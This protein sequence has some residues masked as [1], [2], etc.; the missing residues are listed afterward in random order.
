MF[1]R[2]M[3]SLKYVLPRLFVFENRKILIQF[4]PVLGLCLL[5]ALSAHVRFYLPFTPVPITF[6]SYAV[7]L[8]GVLL[9]AG[10]GA[11]SQ[12]LLIVLGSVG[13]NVFS[14]GSG[15]TAILGP[16][17]GYILGFVLAAYISGVLSSRGYLTSFVKSLFWLFVASLFIFLPGVIWL[18]TFTG[19]SWGHSFQLGFVPFI[20]GDI[21]KTVAVVLTVKVLK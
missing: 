19:V 13:L 10:R 4:L 20:L 6:Q 14:S 18:K 21:V 8:S 9:G 11:M 2:G 12:I 3:S 16:T 7:V 1:D 5:T 15:A 17:G